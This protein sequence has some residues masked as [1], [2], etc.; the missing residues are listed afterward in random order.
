MVKNLISLSVLLFLVVGMG[1]CERPWNSYNQ[2]I[3]SETSLPVASTD[4]VS[5]LTSVN[6]TLK[7]S[8]HTVQS[9]VFLLKIS[10]LSDVINGNIQDIETYSL[11]ITTNTAGVI[12]KL[13]DLIGETTN[14]FRQNQFANVSGSSVTAILENGSEITISS[15][16][17]NIPVVIASGTVSDT[18]FEN[19]ESDG[20]M[21]TITSPSTTTFYGYGTSF[22]I[23]VK[24]S[25]A[26]WNCSWMSGDM[27]L[28]GTDCVVG[29]GDS[30]V[31]PV[32]SPTTI[33]V[34]IPS[35]SGISANV[36]IKGGKK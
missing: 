13:I 23:T 12:L 27:E 31:L 22:A 34:D 2:P 3:V 33:Y 32:S 8:T 19:M 16:V 1:F 14:N 36:Y 5:G 7:A 21:A 25:T 18:R 10:T 20:V 6:N 4:V 9:N 28:D 24:G 15:S 35:G 11:N 26:I 30:F 29:I 17:K